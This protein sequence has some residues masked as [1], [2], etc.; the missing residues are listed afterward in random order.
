MYGA[1]FASCIAPDGGALRLKP[2]GPPRL[3]AE[4]AAIGTRW[5]KFRRNSLG[6]YGVNWR[7]APWPSSGDLS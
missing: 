1:I 4:P 5:A 3:C 7:Q 2:W 6:A